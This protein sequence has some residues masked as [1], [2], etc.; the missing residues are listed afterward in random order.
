VATAAFAQQGVAQQVSGRTAT[1]L[2]L[3]PLTPAEA[4][5][6]QAISL[7]NPQVRA[8]LG[9][10][11]RLVYALSIAPKLTPDGEPHG[12]HAEVLYIRADN[13]YGLLVLVD[14]VAGRVVDQRRVSSQAVPLGRADVVEALRIANE[15]PEL[16]R[17]LG[18]RAAGFRVL[19]GPIR[20]ELAASDYVEGLRHTGAGPD[21]PC[22][23]HRC[24][25]LLFN[26]GGRM[27]LQDQEVLVD[28]DTRN[29][30]VTPQRERP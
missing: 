16:R 29:V 11:P 17:L 18:A 27:I 24:V 2:P 3:D 22:S 14:L 5:Q 1:P 19:Q 7:A 15:S 26:S 6:G 21:D 25:F 13:R 10:D 8:Q 20:P 9:D 4:G 28:L 30:T 23:K 12:R